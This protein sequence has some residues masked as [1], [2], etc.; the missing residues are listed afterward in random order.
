MTEIYP[1]LL[2]FWQFLF[3]IILHLW[4][5]FFAAQILFKKKLPGCS[6]SSQISFQCRPQH[7]CFQLYNILP[8]YY[9]GIQLESQNPPHKHTATRL[10][11]WFVTTET[12]TQSDGCRVAAMLVLAGKRPTLRSSDSQTHTNTQ[13]HTLFLSLRLSRQGGWVGSM[14]V[15]VC[16]SVKQAKVTVTW[17]WWNNYES[18]TGLTGSSPCPSTI[19]QLSL[20]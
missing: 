11:F 10:W 9:F 3:Q 18:K 12:S 16:G 19:C 6:S 14:C 20:T 13:A 15:C 7:N 8:K 5:L 1:S 17:H 2:L 4:A